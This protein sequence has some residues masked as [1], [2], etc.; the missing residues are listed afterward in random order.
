MGQVCCCNERIRKIPNTF[1]VN[2]LCEQVV[3]TFHK[4]IHRCFKKNFDA[5]HTQVKLRETFSNWTAKVLMVEVGIT[6]VSV[7]T[8]C[9][10]LNGMGLLNK[11]K[12]SLIACMLPNMHACKIDFK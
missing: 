7:R 10:L 1:D 8:V 9:R 3:T 6:H 5:Y 11:R 12:N 2:C 4:N